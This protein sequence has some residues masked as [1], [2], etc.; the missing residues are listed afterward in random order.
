LPARRS[1]HD[2]L[3]HWLIDLGRRAKDSRGNAYYQCSSGDSEPL[4]VRLGKKHVPYQPDV[5]WARRGKVIIFELAF[6]EDWRSIVGELALASALKNLDS[7]MIITAGYS[8][9]FIE[10]LIPL[11]GERLKIVWA[12][13]NF[14]DDEYSDV[15]YMKEELRKILKR[16]DWI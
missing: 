14:S 6:N 4:D 5:I 9:E 7:I 16:W 3:K 12:H 11:F 15:D 2:E 10:N 8:D 13:Y 1:P